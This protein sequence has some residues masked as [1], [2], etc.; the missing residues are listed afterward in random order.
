M[1][2]RPAAPPNHPILGTKGGWAGR[3]E[4]IRQAPSVA[5]AGRAGDRRRIGRTAELWRRTAAPGPDQPAATFWP[6]PAPKPEPEI[7]LQP[8]A[9]PEPEES[10][11]EPKRERR[12]TGGEADEQ[13]R[14]RRDKDGGL[15]PG[16]IRKG[17]EK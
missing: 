13:P 15:S 10:A 7:V 1:P 5:R 11:P 4:V 14:K 2:P 9:E 16:Q 3:R 12:A 6:A 17:T 8:R